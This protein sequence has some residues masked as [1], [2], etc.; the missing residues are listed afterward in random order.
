MRVYL[1]VC[2]IALMSAC[3][4]STANAPSDSVSSSATQENYVENS[5]DAH[6]QA[7]EQQIV[8]SLCALFQLDTVVYSSRNFEIG[9]GDA[10]QIFLYNLLMQYATEEQINICHDLPHGNMLDYTDASF[11]SLILAVASAN[12]V[13]IEQLTGEYPIYANENS[14]KLINYTTNE[15]SVRFLRVIDNNFTLEEKVWL[16][17]IGGQVALANTEDQYFV[18]QMTTKILV[19]LLYQQKQLNEL[20]Q[21]LKKTSKKR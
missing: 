20:I 19:K 18:S 3:K 9:R 16:R 17:K 11:L 12:Q 14:T 8:D 21:S 4:Q 5:E 7:E 13:L 2:C 10:M 1:L 15:A 6:Y